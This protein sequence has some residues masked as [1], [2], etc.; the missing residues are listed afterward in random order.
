MKLY[1]LLIIF[2][3]LFSSCTPIRATTLPTASIETKVFTPSPIPPTITNSPSLIAILPTITPSFTPSPFPTPTET[4]TL[5]ATLEPAQASD[6]IKNLTQGSEDCAAPCFWGIT[7]GKT[8]TG[9][10]KNIFTHLGLQMGDANS[11]SGKQYYGVMYTN[12]KDIDIY[13]ILTIQN[14]IVLNLEV[15]INIFT[16]K[17]GVSRGLS[18]YSPQTLIKRYGMPSRVDFGADWG[19]VPFF[20]MQMYFDSKDLIVQYTGTDIIPRQHHSSSQVCPMTAHFETVWLWMG[21]NPKDPPGEALGLENATSLTM[22][23]FSKLMTG[24]PNHACFIFKGDAFQ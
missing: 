16:Y 7:P 23:D 24:N 15:K 21:K 6:K 19:P 2:V 3:L 10:A 20:A 22:E 18:A 17:I 1:H 12:K 14:D 4:M 11:L 9:E 8:T 13:P 5:P